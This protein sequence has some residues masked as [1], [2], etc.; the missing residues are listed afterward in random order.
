MDE[1]EECDGEDYCNDECKYKD[2]DPL[3][4][5]PHCSGPYTLIWSVTNPNLYSVPN[6]Y[7]VLDGAVKFDGTFPAD[8]EVVMGTTAD[9]PAAHTMTATWEGG[10]ASVTST[11]ECD[12]YIPPPVVQPDPG[13][14]FIIPVTGADLLGALASKQ[15]MFFSIGAALLGASIMIGRTKK[16]K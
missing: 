3:T 7:V 9:G 2:F 1:G 12:G 16:K 10:S 11:E 6:T 14:A 4:L 13:E 8:T 15:G 5:D